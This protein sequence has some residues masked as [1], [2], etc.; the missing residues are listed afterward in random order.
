MCNAMTPFVDV[1]HWMDLIEFTAA[2]RA[3][4]AVMKYL[5]KGLDGRVIEYEKSG[6]YASCPTTRSVRR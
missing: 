2:L 4:T 1:S 6:T 5:V 3:E